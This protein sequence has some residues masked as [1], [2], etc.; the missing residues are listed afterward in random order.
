MSKRLF[1][2]GLVIAGAT[3]L[4]AVVFADFQGARNKEYTFRTIATDADPGEQLQ[5]D[6]QW[7]DGTP[8][9]TYPSSS[10]YIPA[11][12]PQDA[13]HTF[14][15]TGSYQVFTVAVDDNGARSGDSN[16][17]TVNIQLPSTPG[18]P[19]QTT[20]VGNWNASCVAS[21]AD[22]ATNGDFTLK[23]AA[24]D[25]WY[26]VQI[27]QYL[28]Q[29]SYTS[30]SG[31]GT[32]TVVVSANHG[33]GTTVWGVDEA[34]LATGCYTY[35]VQAEDNILPTANQ[36]A[37]SGSS[38]DVIVDTT[39]PG[40][41]GAPSVPTALN[42]FTSDTSPT[43]E[44]SAITDN[45]DDEC[46]DTGV[47]EYEFKITTDVSGN[48]IYEGPVRIAENGGATYTYTQSP[49]AE[50]T[51]YAFVRAWD[52][53]GNAGAW[54]TAGSVIIG[55]GS[56]PTAQWTYCSTDQATTIQFADLSE[57]S[58]G[59]TVNWWSW[60]FGDGETSNEQNPLHTYVP[61]TTPP[62]D[63]TCTP[64]SSGN[65]HTFNNSVTVTCT[66]AEPGVVIR[67]TTD[68]A[69]PTETSTTYS[70]PLTFTTSLTLKVRAWDGAG[71][72]SG[73]TTYTYTANAG[74]TAQ[75]DSASTGVDTAVDIDV[76][77]NDSD[78][79][80]IDATTVTIVT[81]PTS[82]AVSVNGTTGVVTYTPNTGFAGTDTFTY[83]VD[84]T[85]GA[86]SNE[87]TVTVSVTNAPADWW[88]IAWKRRRKITFNNSGQA[89]NLVDFPA[90]IA[91]DATTRSNVDY[92][93]TQ[94][95]GED[96]RFVDASANPGDPPLDYEIEEWNE[97][98]VSY[99]WVKVPQIDGGS[100]TDYIWMYY[101]NSGAA[102]A[103]NPSGVWSN[104]YVAVWHMKESAAGTGNS[105]VY[106]NSARSDGTGDADDYYSDTGKTGFI[107]SGQRSD[108]DDY[109]EVVD[110]TGSIFDITGDLT[111]E[112]WIYPTT[113][114]DY[115]RF[116][117]KQHTSDVSPFDMYALMFNGSN[118]KRL[119]MGIAIGGTHY[120]YEGTSTLPSNTWTYVAGARRG[121][122]MGIAVNGN[123]EGGRLVPWGN[124]DTNDVP[125][126][127]GNSR[128]VSS[129]QFIGYIDEVRISNVGR[130][131]DWTKAQYLSMKEASTPG[132]FVTFGAEESIV[133][134]QVRNIRFVL[135]SSA[136]KAVWR[137]VQFAGK[138]KE[139]AAAVVRDMYG[140]VRS[141]ALSLPD[142]WGV[143]QALADVGP[144][145]PYMVTLQ[146][147]DTGGGTDTSA[148]VQLDFS[149]SC[150]F[151]L[152][153]VEATTCQ[154][155]EVVEWGH[156]EGANKYVV[157][158]DSDANP[159]NGSYGSAEVL[160]SDCSATGCTYSI[161]GLTP[162]TEYYIYIQAI[163]SGFYNSY[164]AC[165]GSLTTVCPA[166][167]RTPTCGVTTVTAN[168]SECGVIKLEWAPA[169]GADG[170]Y[171]VYRSLDDTVLPS[172]SNGTVM[173]HPNEQ[174]AEPLNPSRTPAASN[175]GEKYR[176]TD[177]GNVSFE[178]RTV[179]TRKK[180]F[181]RIFAFNA[182]GEAS[183]G[184]DVSATSF[185][186]EGPTFKEK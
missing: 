186:F 65:T 77:A 146:V 117:G 101:G 112:A 12:S 157:Y 129:Q 153:N 36:S 165:T 84:D 185:C 184:T 71:N 5:Y 99:V 64:P 183:S 151:T 81:N 96:I 9:E 180:Y 177:T 32:D 159:A 100:N 53:V 25:P 15:A 37:V 13:A 85:L 54:S 91:L 176:F 14:T 114:R 66:D 171:D 26:G 144:G 24:S 142:R 68:G 57:P 79:D 18:I 132:S 31:S 182:D 93:Q 170:G 90:L 173:P 113:P 156:A 35:Q 160:R 134:Y 67:Y 42:G 126:R 106:K 123:I 83:T 145:G 140:A 78:S 163:P 51:Y 76:T 111:L 179:L 150:G 3:A 166:I 149:R 116:V 147:Q 92:A 128:N 80:G 48:V 41:M 19:C 139:K 63:P 73:I 58:A 4:P 2:I 8:V 137:V 158:W 168:E 108:S 22:G 130:S 167:K 122:T 69:D 125:I 133:Q 45:G 121:N 75:D 28:V 86:T 164:Q 107:G 17:I 138:A 43:W 6:F 52:K 155:I 104:G 7:G 70:S 169:L 20:Q 110:T 21:S 50:G 38:Q 115:A 39:A 94:N 47:K 118:P 102:D 178:D 88:D 59:N 1:I 56:P 49:S 44:F 72:A 55:T 119:R 34:G 61:D 16:I 98:G 10:T 103:Q 120:T 89:E 124:L 162:S 152:L 23:W 87:A 109:G 97:A 141:F 29:R 105:G 11:G 46:W 174:Q 82:G 135:R 33:S 136:E 60:D 30:P 40:Q 175:S 27:S 74:P 161:N 181:Y 143:L 62:P 154:S 131:D 148:P 172:E 95:N 127:I